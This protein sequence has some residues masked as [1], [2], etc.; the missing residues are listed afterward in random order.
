MSIPVE[1]QPVQFRTTMSDVVAA[2]DWVAT[3]AGDLLSLAG[4]DLSGGIGAFHRYF[5][6]GV[7]SRSGLVERVH[8]NCDGAVSVELLDFSGPVKDVGGPHSIMLLNTI[9]SPG[10]HLGTGQGTPPLPIL[11]G[12]ESQSDLHFTVATIAI[13]VFAAA[14]ENVV[15]TVVVRPL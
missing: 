5:Y 2:A 8:L 3:Q 6:M 11:Y 9:A 12:L 10:V 15:L 1:S 4:A 14:R 7:P 13:R